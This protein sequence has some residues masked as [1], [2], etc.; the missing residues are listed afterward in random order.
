MRERKENVIFHNYCQWI[1]VEKHL[2]VIEPHIIYFVKNF[3]KY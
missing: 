1:G 3:D 2:S